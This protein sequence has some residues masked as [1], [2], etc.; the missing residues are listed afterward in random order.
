[1]ISPATVVR[2]LYGKEFTADTSK[3]KLSVHVYGIAEQDGKI[4]IS[5]QFDGFDFPGG[6]AEKGETHLETL[7]REFKE[8]TGYDIEPMGI[9]D[10]YTAFFHH[11]RTGDG[12]QAYLIYYRV[13][14]TG[15][16]LSDAGFDEAE[17]SYAKLARWVTLNELKSMRHVCSVDI[18]DDLLEK[19]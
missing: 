5:P 10:V 1:M 11:I 4:L 2:D 16:E 14:I 12:Y 13:K 6:T 7:K 19:L 17:R 3:L 15:G 18:V 8:E 9:I